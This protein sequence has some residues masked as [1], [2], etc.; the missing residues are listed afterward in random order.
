MD[1][2]TG[3]YD[4]FKYRIS[5]YSDNR[6]KVL[7]VYPSISGKYSVTADMTG[8]CDQDDLSPLI[9]SWDSLT[10][11]ELANEL[12]QRP[13]TTNC[14]V[15]YRVT[16]IKWVRHREDTPT[17][18]GAVPIADFIQ[19]LRAEAA[20]AGLRAPVAAPSAAAAAAAAP[21]VPVAAPSVAA[22]AA[23]APRA[24]V[25]LPSV[26]EFIQDILANPT[27]YVDKGPVMT[28]DIVRTE[29]V[30]DDNIHAY[31]GESEFQRVTIYPS[32]S[33]ICV[34]D[35]QVAI[36]SRSITIVRKGGASA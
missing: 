35:G 9:S 6:T 10:P 13:Y 30:T 12:E 23:A 8:R 1:T 25:A 16:H 29:L 21:R 36:T 26:E 22:A 32:V 19:Q 20:S 7:G 3:K 34:V 27:N 17:M 5:K 14:G 11:T 4:T 28:T 2:V 33:R 15:A 18:H 24:P 31:Y